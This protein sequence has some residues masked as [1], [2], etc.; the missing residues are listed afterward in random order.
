MADSALAAHPEPPLQKLQVSFDLERHALTGAA[1]LTLP[2]G[3]EYSVNLRGLAISALNLDGNGL[4]A[5]EHLLLPA[6]EKEQ[7]LEVSY[8]KTYAPGEAAD[9]LIGP[10]AIALTGAW[11][12]QLNLDCLFALTAKVPK[13][14]EAVSEAEEI[15][16]TITGESKTVTFN[17]PYPLGGLDLV[18]GPYI[19][20]QDPFGD[21]QILYSYF[22]AEDQELAAEYRKKTLAYLKRYTDLLGP[23]PYK[24]FSIVE[25][26]LPT[27]YAMPTF[28]LLGQ[29][30]VR[31]PF[32]TE[33]SLGHE[34]LHSWFG[35]SVFVDYAAGNWC[36]GLA[37]YLADHAFSADKGEDT[38]FRKQQLINYQ[39]Y[40]GPENTLALKDFGGGMSHL[41]L[42]GKEQRAVGYGKSSMLFHM[43]RRQIG[44]AAFSDGLRDFYQ[45]LRFRRA[46]W[47]DLE[48]SFSKTAGQDLGPFF[49]Q[50]LN[51]SDLP[52][53]EVSSA[54]VEE[55]DGR[56]QLSLTI[57][58]LQ[59][60]PYLLAVP[61]EIITP[62]GNILQ[63]VSLS[64]T[65]TK[66]E[67]PLS[68]PPSTLVLDPN[69]D[70]MRQ[71]TAK[72]LP[73]AWSR[74][75]GAR[76]KLAIL[77]AAEEE[78]TFAPLLEILNSLDCPTKS[79][80]E[81]T[82]KEVA[83][84]AVLFLGTGSKLARSLFAGPRH[85]A[86]GF[87][88]DVRQ[89]PLGPTEVAVLIN[90]A[91]AEETAAAGQKLVHY[92]KYGFLHFEK[93]RIIN[94]TVPAAEQG[95]RVEIDS[96]PLGV[97]VPQALSFA[98]IAG[99]LTDK[100]VIYVG[101]T[102]TRY[103]DHLLQLRV[104]R[105]LF[106]RNPKL[107]IGMEMFSRDMQ[108]VLD[109]YLAQEFDEREFLK[110][111]SYFSKWG[112]DYR[113]YRDLINFARANKIPIIA[114]NQEK[115][116]V[117]KIFKEGTT[118]ALTEENLAKIPADRDLS[119]PGYRERIADVF[120][121]HG[122]HGATPEQ[123][124]GFIQ[125]QALWDETMAES[126]ADYL[127]ANPE[128]RMVVIA[129]QGHTAKSTAIPPR[130]A[131]RLPEIQQAVILNAEGAE[132]DRSEADYLIFCGPQEL[133]PAPLLGVMLSN[134][135]EGV[136]V[137]GL[138]EQG[139]G[140]E[141]GIR[142]KDVILAVDDE[143]VASIDDLKIIMLYKKKGTPVEVRIRR[144]SGFLFKT[145]AEIRITVPL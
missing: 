62:T 95:L 57:K 71:L 5:T 68:A 11:H 46:G 124:N 96:P 125:A 56:P 59:K 23:Y 41:S 50:W 30:V 66:L 90:S 73:P 108:T 91:N 99:Q 29:A 87:T 129:G 17:F 8:S 100:R 38:E 63:S 10:D 106:S 22:F 86:T 18:A 109:G 111:S 114:L 20:V 137:S 32:I 51:R 54:V 92:G 16:S 72:E 48:A 15:S 110:K 36:E 77:P 3:R 52:Q 115:E 145:D 101:E 93:G 28:T 81:V 105:A 107:A 26:R 139:K 25:N 27:G 31:L 103:A 69:Y 21:G 47:Q 64:G 35:N 78:Q 70:L 79:P 123:V 84:K 104:A 49:S 143:P 42:L 132:P 121:M 61:L 142:E 120:T 24:R 55:Q 4:P 144:K 34:V 98:D 33:T 102:H 14:F 136:L 60:E 138:S 67:L 140:K 130:L 118:S 82:D 65:E 122:Q 85:P 43:L 112:Y 13:D 80:A 89:N 113:L 19:I 134:S 53:L 127:T 133:P 45:R 88:L 135:E 128:H 12:P 58:Q 6:K 2:A 119:I 76:N 74:F 141:A 94:K 7:I 131:R 126:V 39:S 116:L 40:V 1:K 37:T 83:G 117:S 44:D 75:A 97:A 9:G